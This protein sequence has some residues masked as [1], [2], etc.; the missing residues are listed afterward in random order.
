MKYFLYCTKFK[1]FR[2]LQADEW[3]IL[4][5]ADDKMIKVWNLGKNFEI[6][7]IKNLTF[8]LLETGQRLQTLKSH[9]DGVTCLQFND[10]YIVSGGILF[11]EARG[12]NF[13]LRPRRHPLIN[14]KFFPAFVLFLIL[15]QLITLHI[16][17]VR[18]TFIAISLMLTTDI[19][20]RITEF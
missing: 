4:S 7:L 20:N 17:F 9:S 6:K 10:F 2:C 18:I 11:F 1:Y 8:H 12:G 5:A 14:K 13:F 16:A 19:I 3:R 15:S